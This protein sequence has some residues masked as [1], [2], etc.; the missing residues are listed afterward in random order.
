MTHTATHQDCPNLSTLV[1]WLEGSLVGTKAEHVEHHLDGCGLCRRRALDWNLRANAPETDTEAPAD[2]IDE[3]TL[4]AYSSA[5]EA[6]GRGTVVQVEQHLQQC[7]RCVSILQHFMRVERLLAPESTPAAYAE[8]VSA[9]VARVPR[10]RRA[11]EG[12]S[13]W[14]QRLREFLT[15]NVWAGAALAAA[16]ALVL[17]VGVTRFLSPS[18][19]YEDMRVRNATRPAPV[20]ITT[21]TVGRPR[22][23]ADEPVVVELPSGTQG[24][25]LEASGEWTRIELEDGR[26]VW[27]ESKTVTRVRTD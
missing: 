15:P 2:C 6:L 7:A 1:A 17:A 14:S 9:E 20:E 18:G 21:D 3:E 10:A 13:P 26:R 5:A 19:P 23:A 27:V 11:N 22:P 12:A 25:W 4:V 16:M 8:P 24:Q